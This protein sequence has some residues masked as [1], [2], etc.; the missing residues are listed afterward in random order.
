MDK[1]PSNLDTL[2][3]KQKELRRQERQEARKDIGS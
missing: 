3:Q 1:K 2:K